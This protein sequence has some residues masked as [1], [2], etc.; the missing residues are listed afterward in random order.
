MIIKIIKKKITSVRYNNI[1]YFTI[2]QAHQGARRSFGDFSFHLFPVLNSRLPWRTSFSPLKGSL[3]PRRGS[4][5]QRGSWALPSPWPAFRTWQASKNLVQASVGPLPCYGTRCPW[6]SR[7]PGASRGPPKK[8]PTLR[9]QSRSPRQIPS[10]ACACQTETARW[11]SWQP[12][13]T[14]AGCRRA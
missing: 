6:A 8:H 3:L 14:P 11:V 5:A 4:T 10:S 12:S 1:F 9:L 13:G 2:R 7:S